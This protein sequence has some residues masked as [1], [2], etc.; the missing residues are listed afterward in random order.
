MRSSSA[1]YL[2]D[3]R[4]QYFVRRPSLL[5]GVM[6]LHLD[7]TAMRVRF[8]SS[9][10]MSSQGFPIERMSVRVLSSF[11]V[12]RFPKLVYRTCS[13]ECR[14]HGKDNLARNRRKWLHVGPVLIVCPRTGV[15]VQMSVHNGKTTVSIKQTSVRNDTRLFNASKRWMVVSLNCVGAHDCQHIFIL[16][17]FPLQYGQDGRMAQSYGGLEA[18]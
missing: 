17:A 5:R 7:I 18:S 14:L 1:V 10:W 13:R 15:M 2:G 9:A 8:G 12:H 16:S 4:L 6:A 11:G 3:F